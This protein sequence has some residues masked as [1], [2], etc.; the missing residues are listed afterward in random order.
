MVSDAA[1][2][3]QAALLSCLINELRRAPFFSVSICFIVC[4]HMNLRP[5]T[6]VYQKCVF[7]FISPQIKSN[8]RPAAAS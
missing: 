8:S 4:V 7:W 3:L 2:T 5:V 1:P 6:C